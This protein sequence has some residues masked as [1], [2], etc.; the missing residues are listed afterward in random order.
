MNGR[1]AILA[2]AFIAVFGQLASSA[3]ETPV[4]SQQNTTPRALSPKLLLWNGSASAPR[5]L[6]LLRLAMPLHSGELVAVAPP[7]PLARFAAV[8]GY[9]PIG[10]PLLKHIAALDGQTVCRFARIVWVNG[11]AVAIARERDSVGRS[12]PSWQGC[13]TLRA[14]QVFLLNPTIPD[15]FDGRYFGV[16][17][18]TAIT[19]RAEPLWTISE[20]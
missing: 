12:L 1:T 15:S 14:G 19:A 10:V 2:T 16:L 6:Y 13:R 17:P 20:H 18:A 3:L 5:G 7:E 11:R 9:L 8:R 4:V